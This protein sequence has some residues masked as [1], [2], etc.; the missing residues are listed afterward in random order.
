MRLLVPP[1]TYAEIQRASGSEGALANLLRAALGEAYEPFVALLRAEKCD[2]VVVQ[3]LD[4]AYLE[5]SR[6]ALA[7]LR[8]PSP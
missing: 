3:D 5:T 6:D 7:P 1:A 4:A 2:V 8:V